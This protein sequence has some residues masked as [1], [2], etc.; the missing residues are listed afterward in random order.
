MVT[1]W[2]A[3]GTSRVAAQATG[4][5]LVNAASFANQVTD[6]V[7]PSSI[8][9]VFGQFVTTGNTIHRAPENVLP[10]PTTLGGVQVTIGGKP[11]SLFF[12]SLF[13]INLAVPGDLIDGPAN[14][15]VTNSDG[16]TRTGTVRI[17][18]SQMGLFTVN[19]SGSGT[20]AA[21]TTQNGVLFQ[22][23]LNPDLTP[24]PVD[25]GT[26]EQPNFLVLFGTGF[27]GAPV[28]NP[29]DA[30][31]VAEAYEATVQG[32]PVPLLYAGPA[33][34]FIGLDQ[35]NLTLPPELSGFGEVDILIRS[36]SRA[37]NTV[38]ITLGGQFR[39]FRL[40]PLAA[41]TSVDGELTATDQVQ[42]GPTGRSFFFDGYVIETTQPNTT[43][44]IDLRSQA[45]DAGVLLFS[46]SNQQLQQIGQDDQTGGYGAP[47]SANNNNALL[48]TVIPTPGQY[49]IF[50]TSSDFQPNGR[51]AYQLRYTTGVIQQISY[52]QTRNGEITTTDLR[53][54]AN[55]LLD[56]YW[57]A[58][59]FGESARI[60]LSSQVFDPYLILHSN[61]GDPPVA[62]DDNSGG[63]L[64]SQL[65]YRLPASGINVILATPFEADRTGTYTL[66]LTRATATSMASQ[67]GL[68][69]MR[70]FPEVGG[71]FLP[72]RAGVES[73]G[74]R[75]GLREERSERPWVPAP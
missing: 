52:G 64:N 28:M 71:R 17:L 45:F 7:A 49:A 36:Q 60:N 73:G 15:V 26:A 2:L 32:V 20:A 59:L 33:P 69:Q 53:N 74:G 70:S 66:S 62:F 25:P 21:L 37:S 63:G 48:L 27:R 38:K 65:T 24:R 41:G 12:V 43:L 10:L 54:S 57:F 44:A 22:S 51:G 72:R 9:S 5:T 3:T 55:V 47:E 13:Q 35:L 61:E 40:A 23:V 50:A 11:A 75:L 56:V 8:G 14:L 29:N 31:G 4:A 46:I 16:T 67:V 1:E 18:R 34:G 6:G 68:F 42:P 58:G 39:P 30:N 19:A